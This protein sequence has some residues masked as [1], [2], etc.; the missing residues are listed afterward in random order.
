MRQ[1]LNHARHFINGNLIDITFFSADNQR[2]TVENFAFSGEYGE[3]AVTLPFV[4]MMTVVDLN[5][6]MADAIIDYNYELTA[7]GMHNATQANLILRI[8]D[9]SNATFAR[10]ED[11]YVAADPL[12]TE[13]ENISAIS[14]THFW[15]IAYSNEADLE[16]TIR[17]TF[18]ANNSDALDYDLLHGHDMNEIVLLYR[19]DAADDWQ[20]I[21]S[22]ISGNLSLGYLSTDTAPAGEYAIGIGN[23]E[24]SVSDSK[25]P[26][27]VQIYP[28]PANHLL[29]ITVDDWK[30][31]DSCVYL[32]LDMNGSLVAKGAIG[33]KQT[34]LN[35]KSL[36]SGLYVV[37]ILSGNQEIGSHKFIKN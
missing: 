34:K 8:S 17:F 14:N 32:I 28:N 30:E 23:R 20:I 7:T 13:N 37:R 10:V 25:S 5:E 2:Y 18:R 36:P 9:I 33:K 6:E 12:K 11:N 29:N 22:S 24:T 31:S 26:K 3:G 35:V 16:G 21:P 27:S 1:R 19:R 15:R 4:P